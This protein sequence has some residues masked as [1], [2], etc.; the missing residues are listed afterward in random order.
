MKYAIV[1]DYQVVEVSELSDEQIQGRAVSAQAVIC[2]DGL[3]PLPSI[4]W[5]LSG[6]KLLPPVFGSQVDYV[7]TVIYDP[8]KQFAEGLSRQF[9]AENISWGVTQL[10]KTRAVGDFMEPIEKWWKRYSMFEVIQELEVAK[11]RL[12]A[13][14]ALAASLAPFVTATRLDEYKLKILKYLGY[15]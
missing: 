3:S 2:I 4:G 14:P 8:V 6:N 10:G 11:G 5:T 12:Q 1:N 15:A 13:D 9:I 7:M